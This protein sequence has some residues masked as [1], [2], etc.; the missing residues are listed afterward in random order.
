MRVINV[1]ARV[2]TPSL[3]GAILDMTVAVGITLGLVPCLC[4]A[5]CFGVYEALRKNK[6]KNTPMSPKALPYHTRVPMPVPMQIVWYS[7]KT[8]VLDNPTYAE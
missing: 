8:F 4:V 3:I 2:P 7:H 5:D 6:N 1:I